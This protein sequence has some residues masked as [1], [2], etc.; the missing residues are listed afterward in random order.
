MTINLRNQETDKLV[1]KLAASR[2]I[3]LTEAVHEAV[4]E[5]LTRDGESA[6]REG[7]ALRERLQPL[8]E[9]LDRLPRT[10]KPTDKQFFD[11]LWGQGDD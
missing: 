1:R 7:A 11:E 4:E 2:G 6:G 5:A 9:R 8:F 10:G 3:G